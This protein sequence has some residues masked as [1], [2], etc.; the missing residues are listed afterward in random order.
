ELLDM[1]RNGTWVDG[2]PV[3]AGQ[4]RIIRRG[5]LV[6]FGTAD[7]PWLVVDDTPPD[8]FAV[9]DD[10][11]LVNARQGMLQLPD[12]QKPELSIY[13]RRHGGWVMERDGAIGDVED[14]AHLYA[15]GARWKLHLPPLDR[16]EVL[17]HE[18]PSVRN[19]GLRFEVSR[20]EEHVEITILTSRA[21]IVLQSR[22]HGYLLL[23]LARRRQEDA[24]AGVPDAERGWI[25]RD[26]LLRMLGIESN[27]LHTL[28]HRARGQFAQEDI[29]DARDLL[30]LRPDS[31][32]W[33]LGVDRI[34]IARM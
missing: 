5:N 15:G 3:G 8:A 6:S 27:Q 1:S 19:L 12:D 28:V 34:S 9:R 13:A 4:R 32:Q 17:S 21:P 18:P 22:A 33:R 23:T 14:Q 7:D 2:Q 10:G 25:H 20:D 16:T 24:H 29:Q 26:D 11:H 30:E 31:G